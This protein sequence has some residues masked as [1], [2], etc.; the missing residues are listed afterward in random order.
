MSQA[1][2]IPLNQTRR[3]QQG[4][5]GRDGHWPVRE[6]GPEASTCAPGET[7]PKESQ[8]WGQH[9]GVVRRHIFLDETEN[10]GAERAPAQHPAGQGQRRSQGHRRPV[11]TRFLGTGD[12]QAGPEAAVLRSPPPLSS[13]SVH[14]QNTPALSGMGL[15]EF[16]LPILEPTIKKKY[17]RIL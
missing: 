2:T 17:G 6:S 7:V 10:P 12:G 15:G 8:T 1:V 14:L 5:Q 3:G 13:A 4:D 16:I 9:E 11:L